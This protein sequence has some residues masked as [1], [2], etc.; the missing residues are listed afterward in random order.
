MPIRTGAQTPEELETLLEDALLRGDHAT[1]AALFR[2]RSVLAARGDRPVY[3]SVE[4]ASRALSLW[5]T[6][7]PYLADP[8]QVVVAHDLG[9]VIGEFGTNVMRRGRSG[10]WQFAIVAQSSSESYERTSS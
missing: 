3:G 4:S 2:P 9:L 6:E 7:H 1:V 8:Q 5:D 10:V